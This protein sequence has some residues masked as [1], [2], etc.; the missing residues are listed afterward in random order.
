MTSDSIDSAGKAKCSTQVSKLVDSQ[1][2]RELYEILRLASL[3]Q[4]DTCFSVIDVKNLLELSG[5]QTPQVV[6]DPKSQ[7]FLCDALK[8]ISFDQFSQAILAMC[9]SDEGKKMAG[10]IEEGVRRI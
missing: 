8:G 5:R 3:H 6:N 4:L 7:K 10:K 9:S 2:I 1:Y